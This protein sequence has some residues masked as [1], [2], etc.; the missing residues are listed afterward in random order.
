MISKVKNYLRKRYC[1]HLLRGVDLKARDSE[2]MVSWACCKCAEIFKAPC[3]L[4]ILGNLKVR[5]DGKFSTK[6]F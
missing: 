5:C 3:G 4:D 6:N 1:N 2:G